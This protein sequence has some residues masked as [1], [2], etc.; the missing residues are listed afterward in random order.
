MM[1]MLMLIDRFFYMLI[2]N[3]FAF[4]P[5]EKNETGSLFKSTAD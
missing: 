5:E 2:F 3:V 4:L 1:L